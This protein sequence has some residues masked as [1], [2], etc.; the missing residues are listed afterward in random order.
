M[1][2][3]SDVWTYY[4]MYFYSIVTVIQP[5]I[6]TIKNIVSV[7][8]NRNNVHR[9]E[10]ERVCFAQVSV[11]CRSFSENVQFVLFERLQIQQRQHVQKKKNNNRMSCTKKWNV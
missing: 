8:I 5:V 9:N 1:A 3:I 4:F 6:E 2:D 7:A 11:Y 10:I